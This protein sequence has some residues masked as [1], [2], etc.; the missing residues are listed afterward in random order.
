MEQRGVS[1]NAVE[2]AGGKLKREKILLPDLAAAVLSRHGG[3]WSG[4]LKAYRLMTE[5]AKRDQVTP[6][7]ATEIE[8]AKRWCT[9][10]V[11]QERFDVLLHI[12]VARAVPVFGGARVVMLERI[13]RN[14]RQ[15]LD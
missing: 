15:I 4:T 13:R 6:G 11:P 10:N 12:V 14:E 2:A 5:S 9:A 7:A 3:E 8:Y 1:E